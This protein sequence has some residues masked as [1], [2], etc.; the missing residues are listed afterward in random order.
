M[1]EAYVDAEDVYVVVSSSKQNRKRLTKKHLWTATGYF[2]NTI[3]WLTT[4]NL[5]DGYILAEDDYSWHKNFE[6]WNLN[7]WMI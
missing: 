4:P 2:L 5:P 7:F 3:L 6:E 1:H